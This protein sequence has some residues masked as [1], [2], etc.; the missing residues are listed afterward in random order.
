LTTKFPPL[1]SFS[2]GE[3]F[4]PFMVRFDMIYGIEPSEEE[5]QTIIHHHNGS[6]P[7][8]LTHEQVV[9]LYYDAKHEFEDDSEDEE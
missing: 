5:G 3:D 6:T 1:V 4:K 7:V 9:E 8:A 2:L